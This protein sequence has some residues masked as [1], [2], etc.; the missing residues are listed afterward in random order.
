[1][2]NGRVTVDTGGMSTPHSKV[3][4]SLWRIPR[5]QVDGILNHRVLD[6]WCR[7]LDGE[8]VGVDLRLPRKPVE[9]K[10]LLSEI[11]GDPGKPDVTVGR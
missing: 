4:G 9:V 2:D 8:L 1:M 3:V 10:E 5:L 11:G 7:R 6:L